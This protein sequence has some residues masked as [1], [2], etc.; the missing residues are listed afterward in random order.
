MCVCY[1]YNNYDYTI[2]LKD[3][4]KKKH[5][6]SLEGPQSRKVHKKSEICQS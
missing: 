6:Q 2:L 5:I 4:Y 1:L 3:R